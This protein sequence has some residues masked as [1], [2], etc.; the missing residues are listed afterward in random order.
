MF[1]KESKNFDAVTVAIPD[2]NHAIVGLRAMQLKKH[3][4]LQ[5]NICAYRQVMFQKPAYF[6]SPN[7]SGQFADRHSGRQNPP[8]KD[9]FHLLTN[10]HKFR[11]F[12]MYAD[13]ACYFW[14]ETFLLF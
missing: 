9:T 7:V 5:T 12:V 3:L 8:F 10:S 14:V 1:D 13:S 4:Y 6:C 11:I 2:H